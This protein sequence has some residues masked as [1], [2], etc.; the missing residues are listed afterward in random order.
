MG[1]V[2]FNG[3]PEEWNAVVE[4]NRLAR[5]KILTELMDADAE[6]GVYD[7]IPFNPD[8]IK[9]KPFN[10]ALVRDITDYWDLGEVSFSR[11]VEMLNEIAIEWHEKQTVSKMETPETWKDIE[12]EY[13]KDEYPVFGGPFTDALKPFEWL[14]KHYHSPK[15]K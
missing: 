13:L 5:E 4:K 10:I 8:N 9:T 15:R 12:E 6:N 3:T 7:N 14:K 11:M 2:Q 1:D